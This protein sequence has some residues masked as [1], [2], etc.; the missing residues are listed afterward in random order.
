[1]SDRNERAFWKA[2]AR[3]AP[4]SRQLAFMQRPFYAFVHFSPNTYTGLEWGDGTED[5]AI[6]NPTDLDCDQW[7]AAIKS[8]GMDGLVLTA[9]HHDG[10]CLWPSRYTEHSVKRSP[11]RGGQGDVVREAAEACRRGGIRFGFYLSPW[12]R[13]CPLYGTDAYNDYYKAQLTELLTEYGEIFYVWFDGA[14]GEGPN[15]K[16]QDYD[17]DGYIELVRRYQPNACIFHDPG[18]DIRWIGN[19]SGTARSA[20]WM[21]VPR[22]V[23]YR[24]PAQTQG[25]LVEGSLCGL[26]N[27]W[28]D[29]GSR[30]IAQYSEGLVFCPAETD[31]SIRPGWF[32]HP[33]EEPH[34]L[35]RLMHTYITSVGGSSTFHLNIPPMPSGRFDERDVQRLKELG[36]ALRE[37]FG[38]PICPDAPVRREIL[39]ET[40][41]VYRVELP[42]AQ[43]VRW[44]TLAEDISQGQR[45]E[46]FLIQVAGNAEPFR[47]LFHGT[48]IGSRRICDLRGPHRLRALEV[49][50]LAARDSVENLSICLT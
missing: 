34:S 36:D 47:I 24:A 43:E 38:T 20:E 3:V 2:A 32:Y 39:S 10:F 35:R 37:A 22:E 27:T 4:S 49:V 28:P 14:C 5:P 29:M 15:G 31:M 11:W 16:K 21:V 48:T 13:N 23:C 17:F 44:V 41:C 45:V 18:P 46:R 8:A 40:Q 1:M 12:D 19:E 30:E 7:V 50:V 42:E 33:E 6:F 9:K 25:P 26:H